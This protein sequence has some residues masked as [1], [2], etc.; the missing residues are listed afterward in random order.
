MAATDLTTAVKAEAARLG[1]TLA[2]VCPAVEPSGFSRLQEWLAA[3]YAGEM[4]HLANRADAYR[5]PARVLEGVRSIVMLAMNYRTLPPQIPQSGEGRVS[6]YAWGL[7]Y[8]DLIRER[9]N[10][11]AAEINRLAPDH[12]SRGVVD[13]APLLEREFAQLAGL[14]WIGKNTLL[15]NKQAGSWFFLAA[16]LTTA[17]LAPD[18]SFESD[19]CGT[20]TACLD[21]C[22]THAFPQPYVLDATK[23]ISYLTIEHRTSIPH[24]LRPGIGQWLFGC[25]VCQ[26]VCPWNH[27]AP[28]AGEHAFQPNDDSNPVDLRALFHLDEATFRKRF[29]GSPIWRAKRRGV[30]RNAAIVLGNQPAAANLEPLIVGLNDPEPLVRGTCSWALGRHS[31]KNAQNALI[32]RQLVEEDASVLAEIEC[33]RTACQAGT[34]HLQLDSTSRFA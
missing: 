8:H 14:G 34:P 2:G 19:H 26:E 23:C 16:M 30:L 10:Q 15:L 31:G 22:P 32:A 1:F 5:D 20:C 11:L 27:R 6:R 17:E 21:A 25:D 4:H 33:A 24:D 28:Q 29:R 18:A 12:V 13:S 3:G 7:D 9:L